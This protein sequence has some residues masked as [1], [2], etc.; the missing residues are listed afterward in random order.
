MVTGEA[1]GSRSRYLKG[2]RCDECRAA[3]SLYVSEYR[4]RN[5]R[6]D[7]GKSTRPTPRIRVD[8][9]LAALMSKVKSPALPGARCRGH[10]AL[11][12]EAAPGEPPKVVAS[13]QLM[14]LELCDGCPARDPCSAW[15]DA[16]P[17]KQRPAGVVAGRISGPTTPKG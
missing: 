17:P 9:V 7:V 10:A 3:S 13:R 2:C 16:L 11:F 8:A 1:H 12:D 14:A 6:S 5:G 15:V 4:A